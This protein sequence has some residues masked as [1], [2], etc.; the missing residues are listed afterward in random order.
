MVLSEAEGGCSTGEGGES[1][2]NACVL[3]GFSESSE[4]RDLLSSLLEIHGDIVAVEFATQ[5]F[6]GEMIKPQTPAKK[7]SEIWI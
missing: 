7:E 4:T 5:R 6:L 3:G 2:V 1:I